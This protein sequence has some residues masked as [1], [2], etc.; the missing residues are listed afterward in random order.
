MMTT[1]GAAEVSPPEPVGSPAPK[2]SFQEL[3]RRIKAAG[4]LDAQPNYYLVKI[5]FNLLMLALGWVALFVVGDS[6]WTLAV[7]VYMG[8]WYTQTGFVGHDIGHRQVTRNRRNQDILG[9]L[10]GNLLMGFS[11]GWWVGH[12]NK[13]H[14]NPNHLEKDSD[15]TRRRAIFIPEQGAMRKGRAKQFIVRYQ[16]ILFYPLLVTEGIGLRTESIKAINAGS[17]DSPRSRQ[18]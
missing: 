10:H 18:C 16:H 9:L 12:H 7:A 14:S 15:I 13:H 11:Y 8:F 3:M 6:W 1:T 2:D 5:I 17:R 4:L